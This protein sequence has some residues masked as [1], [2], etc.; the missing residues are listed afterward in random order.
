VLPGYDSLAGFTLLSNSAVIVEDLRTESR[1][2]APSLLV[3]HGIIS[4]VG[5]IIHGHGRAFGVLGAHSPR[6]RKFSEDDIHFLQA[7]ANVLATAVERRDLEKELVDISS[8]EQRRIGHDLHDGLCQQLAGIKYCAGLIAKKL[9][10]D[11]GAKAEIVKMADR[12]GEAIVQAR[13]LARGLSLVSLESH[14]FLSALEELVASVQGLF[15]I[16]CRFECKQPVLINDNTLATHLYRIAQEAI[17]NAVKHGHAKNVLVALSEA[18]DKITLRIVD[19][20][21]GLMPD[22]AKKTGMGL[23][24]MNYRAHIIGGTFSIERT[25]P[26]GTRVSCSFSL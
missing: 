3:E 16:R 26:T 4:S 25:R 12:I 13:N 6:P 5:A 7:I 18:E 20:G 9:P 15:Q 22:W 24:I 10:S 19:D 14:G 17:H 2:R 23:R 1:F 11:V 8:R 21:T